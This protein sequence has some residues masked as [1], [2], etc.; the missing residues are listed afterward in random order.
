MAEAA[1]NHSDFKH[2]IDELFQFLVCVPGYSPR[3]AIDRILKLSGATSCGSIYHIRGGARKI[4]PMRQAD[5]GGAG[6]EEAYR[7]RH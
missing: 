1:S 6:E 7:D 2:T 5:T 3:Q 4:R